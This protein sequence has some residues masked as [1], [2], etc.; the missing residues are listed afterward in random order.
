[1]IRGLFKVLTDQSTR[2]KWRFLALLKLGKWLMPEYRFQWPGLAW[3]HQEAFNAYLDRFGILEGMESDRRWMLNQLTMLV[4]SVPGDTAECGVLHGSS[5]YLVC[6]AL[7]DRRHFMFDS[8]EGL[9]VPSSADEENWSANILACDLITAQRN[10]SEFSN[11]SFHPGWIP[12]RFKDVES[13]TFSFVHIDVQLYEPTRDSIEFFYPRMSEGGIIICDDYGFANCP[14]ATKAVD[15][16]LSGK[17]EKM[18]S[19]S[20]GSAFLIKGLATGQNVLSILTSAGAGRAA[21][22]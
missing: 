16:F 22:A 3:W 20:C 19:L 5:S 13:R 18:I 1:M 21:G 11:I 7:P 4:K 2:R 12:S 6:K 10:L 17:P 9:S 14:G 15:E 8:F